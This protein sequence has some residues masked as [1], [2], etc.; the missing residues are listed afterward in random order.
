[1]LGAGLDALLFFYFSPLFLSSIRMQ[2]TKTKLITCP[3]SIAISSES[4]PQTW[5]T[6]WN[7]DSRQGNPSKREAMA[8]S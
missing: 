1:M 6:R 4:L 3:S 2:P 8:R 7:S 5:M